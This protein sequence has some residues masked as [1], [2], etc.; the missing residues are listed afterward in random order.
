MTVNIDKESSEEIGCELIGGNKI[1]IYINKVA[2]NSIA[3]R[4]QI[5]RGWRILK[6]KGQIT[7]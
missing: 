1:G 3:E 4:N 5:K 6:V 2:A 7:L